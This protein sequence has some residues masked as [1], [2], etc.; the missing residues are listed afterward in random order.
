VTT[1]L[2]SSMTGSVSVRRSTAGLQAISSQ[3]DER[4]DGLLDL[5]RHEPTPPLP[6]PRLLGPFDP[7]LLGWRSR[8]FVLAEA[9]GIVR[10][11]GI[12]RAI[13]LVDGRAAGT[14]GLPCGRVKLDLGT[15]PGSR[16][17]L[18]SRRRPL[19]SRST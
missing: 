1:L 2:C 14:W 16:L 9:K 11:N 3:L 15:V 12:F 5:R 10:N 8:D 17:L 18:R 4:P 19:P 6:P 7:L 13:A